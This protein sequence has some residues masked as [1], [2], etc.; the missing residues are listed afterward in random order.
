LNSDYFFISSDGSPFSEK[1]QDSA[2]SPLK[3]AGGKFRL[4]DKIIPVL[5]PSS[6]KR[7]LEPFFGGGSVGLNIDPFNIIENTFIVNDSNEAL[8]DFWNAIKNDT[9]Y[10]I[11]IISQYFTPEFNNEIKYYELRKCFNE[12]DDHF[13][14]GVLF[15]YLNKHCFNGLCRFNSKG[16]F[17]VPF[18][19]YTSPTLPIDEI[20]L[21]A[22]KLQN[23]QILNV[24]FRDILRMA[25]DGDCVYC[26]PPYLPLTKTANFSAYGVK[27]FSGTDH[28]DL[29]DMALEASQRGARVVVSNHWTDEAL[30][31][32]KHA[33]HHHKIS[34]PRFIST[35][36]AN[37]NS[38][39]EILVVY[40]PLKSTKNTQSAPG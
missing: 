12:T 35:D 7:F 32:Y 33:S 37:R 8:V 14:K 29:A 17:N 24:D 13:L 11:E 22:K 40:E 6:R 5:L 38:V 39:D 31:I 1:T 10:F 2:R 36:G 28:Q 20:R 21:A 25:N 4:L 18:G 19:K 34:V 30:E 27:E 9:E 16:L 3:W 23:F 15:L 26:D